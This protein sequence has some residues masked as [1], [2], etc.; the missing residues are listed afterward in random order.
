MKVLYIGHYREGSGWSNAT[1]NTILAMD[2]AGVDV[3]CQN[4]QLNKNNVNDDIPKRIKELESKPLCNFT[5]CIQNVLPHHLTA[6]KLF[7]KNIAYY[8]SESIH[9]KT[10]MW[11]SYLNMMDEVWVPNQDMVRCNTTY[12]TKPIKVV[13]FAFDLD[14]YK[15]DRRKINF[16]IDNPKFKFYYIGDLNDRKNLKSIIRCY[17]HTFTKMDQ[18]VFVIKVKKYGMQQDQLEN[19]CR[20][21]CKQVQEEMRTHNARSNYPDIRFIT[22]TTDDDF[23]QSLHN[24][25]DCLI[26]ASLGEAWSI[27]SF[28]AMCY[29]NTPICSNEGGPKD[30]IDHVSTGFLIDG[31]YRICNQQDGA[32]Q[33][34]FTG[35]E[36]WFQP[37]EMKIC[38]AMNYYFQNRSDINRK[39]GIKH[40]EDYSLYNIGTKIKEYLDG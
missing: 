19:Y 35:S 27:P 13:P 20:Q 2:K 31:S 25:C 39:A 22:S 17:Y 3:V 16:G 36:F 23:I 28:E 24:S 15:T 9:T 10:N 6:S 1:I 37:D 18:V 5:H 11:H 21:I 34:L 33:H 12:I 38:N 29:G 4:L 7:D 26:N 32:F 14:K 8:Y 30:F 40:A